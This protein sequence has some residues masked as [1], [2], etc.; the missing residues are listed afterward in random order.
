M[1]MRPARWILQRRTRPLMRAGSSSTS[2]SIQRSC[3]GE[4]LLHLFSGGRPSARRT[5]PP[6]EV[7]FEC[8]CPLCLSEV[9]K[10]HS[11]D[12]DPTALSDATA[13]ADEAEQQRRSTKGE[14]RQETR[15]GKRE[16]KCRLTG[17]EGKKRTKERDHPM[18]RKGAARRLLLVCLV[19]RLFGWLSYRQSL[20]H[21]P[22]HPHSFR[23]TLPPSVS[24]GTHTRANLIILCTTAAAQ[25]VVDTLSLFVSMEAAA[26][27]ANGPSS[28]R[29]ISF[30]FAVLHSAICQRPSYTFDLSTTTS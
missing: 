27:L 6:C 15:R 2:P 5:I 23:L 14:G 13:E 26:S 25:R 10:V 28:A 9:E 4:E 1:R 11:A 30:S 12:F 17:A 7:T 8:V 22:T 21:H 3:K 16:R 19:A 20:S 24:V 18:R 29:G